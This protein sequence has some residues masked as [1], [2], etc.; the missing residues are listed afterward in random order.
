MHARALNTC[1]AI[2]VIIPV[3]EITRGDTNKNSNFSEYGS[4]MG[5]YVLVHVK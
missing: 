2:L 1:P 5:K 3:V 4:V